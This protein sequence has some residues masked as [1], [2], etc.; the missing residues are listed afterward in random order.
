MGNFYV[1]LYLLS[2]SESYISIIMVFI[3]FLILLF[4]ILLFL[5]TYFCYYVNLSNSDNIIDHDYLLFNILV[6]A[7]EEIGSIDDMLLTSV[8]LIYIF[9]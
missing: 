5:I 6:E 2:F 8:V 4:L 3:Q 1:S 7:E 9:F